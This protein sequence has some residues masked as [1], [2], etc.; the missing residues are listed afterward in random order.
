MRSSPTQG[1]FEKCVVLGVIDMHL[2]GN[3][4]LLRGW[5]NTASPYTSKRLL[6][7]VPIQ[8]TM[9]GA[10][11]QT[12]NTYICLFELTICFSILLKVLWKLC[13]GTHTV[14]APASTHNSSSDWLIRD[15]WKRRGDKI[16]R[17]CIR[18]VT[19]H[20][21][22]NLQNSN[23]QNTR[24]YIVRTLYTCTYIHTCTHK[25]QINE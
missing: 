10:V 6:L 18:A 12:Y 11:R 15:G 20:L 19:W 7:D 16:V 2:V 9:Y 3:V 24:F 22:T 25:L 14:G 21:H 17:W 13:T 4:N 23:F 5:I 1:S 8:C